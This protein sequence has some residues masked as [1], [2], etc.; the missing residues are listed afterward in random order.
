MKCFH[1]QTPQSA[2]NYTTFKNP[3]VDKLIDEAGAT[4]DMAKRMDL[5]K[6]AN[7]IV[8][9]E[10]PVWFFNYN[11]AVMAYQPWL[12]GLQANATELALQYYEDLWVDASSPAAK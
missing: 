12:H 7:A 8:Y 11:K 3:E 2:C 1:S 5:L 10:A 6:K 9:D 4:D